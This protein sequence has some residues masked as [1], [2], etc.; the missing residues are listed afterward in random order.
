MDWWKRDDPYG[1]LEAQ[2]TGPSSPTCAR[3]T[4]TTRL[5]AFLD[6]TAAAW[7]G[8]KA[9]RHEASLC[10]PTAGGGWSISL[11]GPTRR[12]ASIESRRLTELMWRQPRGHQP[13]VGAPVEH[14]SG[15]LDWLRS[16]QG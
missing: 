9:K 14:A 13:A 12:S 6:V 7:Q 4:Q 8:R 1:G 11:S 15:Q 2:A 16:M 5:V 10:S 3:A